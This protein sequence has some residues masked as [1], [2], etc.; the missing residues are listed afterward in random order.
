MKIK[1]TPCSKFSYV[2]VTDG[3]ATIETGLLDDSER[4]EVCKE[5]LEGAY[6]LWPDNNEASFDDYLKEWMK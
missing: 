2:T 3:S 4:I 1:V 6:F 5:F